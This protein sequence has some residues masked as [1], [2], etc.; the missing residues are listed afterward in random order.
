VRPGET[1]LVHGTGGVALFGLQIAKARGAS[2]I[3]VSGSEEKLARAKRLGAAH[4]IDRKSED[5]VEAVY[6]LTGDHGANHILETVG[7][8]Q[9]GRSIEAAAIDGRISVIGVLD[10]FE[11]S[12]PVGP[13]LLKGLTLQGIGVGHRRALEDFVRAVDQLKLRPTI[14][15]RYKFA[16][17]PKA[18]DHL[19]R[20]PFGKI[21]IELV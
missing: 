15:A 6:R 4:G 9:L 13:L 7:G 5:W 14:D 1:V 19:D 11:V 16:E 3:V 10:G 18:L 12:G 20:G 2:V 17:L 21:V 8:A